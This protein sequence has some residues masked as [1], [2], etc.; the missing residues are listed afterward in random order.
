MM[1]YP[2]F[3]SL[4]TKQNTNLFYFSCFFIVFVLGFWVNSGSNFMDYIEITGSILQVAIPCYALVPILWKKDKAGVK[5][6]LLMLI[7]VLS[8]TYILKA[9]LSVKRPY[10][11]SMSFPSGHTA[12][13]FLGAIYLSL[14]YRLYYALISLPL[15]AFVGISRILSR[16]HWPSDV[17]GAACIS[18]AFGLLI[19]KSYRPVFKG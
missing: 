14:R 1:E 7:F 10:G 9:S 13:A 17:V 18:L 16:N 3:L 8:T 2:K 19:V 12:S 4:C 15:A 5:Q 11:G 6:M